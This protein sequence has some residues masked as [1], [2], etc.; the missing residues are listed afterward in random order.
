MYSEYPPV[1]EQTSVRPL[2]MY[3]PEYIQLLHLLFTYCNLLGQIADICPHC[4]GN[5]DYS[6]DVHTKLCDL[7]LT[8]S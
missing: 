2:T 1:L 5:I 4:V 8:E 3:G 7:N 6:N